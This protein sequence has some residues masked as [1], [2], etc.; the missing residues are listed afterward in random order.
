VA[1]AVKMLQADAYTAT[2]VPVDRD[3]R[4]SPEA[5][6]AAVQPD[7]AIVACMLVQNELGTIQPVAE[8]ARAARARR[9]EIQIHC[10]A[11]QALGK[12]PID[13]RALGVDTLAV[14]AHKLHGPKGVGALWTKKGARL[15]PLWGGAQQGGLRAGTENV[16]GIAAFGEAAQRATAALG[17][18]AARLARLGERLI[19]GVRSAVPNA[20]VNGAG[21]PRVAHIVSIAFPGLPAEPLLHALEAQGVLV[22]AGSACS[23]KSAK[24]SSVLAAIG[25]RDDAGV[26]RF[27]F[28]RDTQERDVDAALAALTVAVTQVAPPALR[29][30]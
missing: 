10:D 17:D 9:A 5:V 18:E 30:R 28:S 6:A 1:S 27:S 15:A 25:L 20:L 19:A 8:V 26:I 13:V 11:V 14:A 24:R 3:G 22:S 2:I 29:A 7:T 21:A 16:A 23:S 4:V 12:L